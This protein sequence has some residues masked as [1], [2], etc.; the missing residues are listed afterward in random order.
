MY[1]ILLMLVTLAVV[2]QAAEYKAVFDCSSSDS[3]YIKSRMWLVGKTIDMIEKRGDTATV[4]LT[5]HG[6]CVQMV[7]QDYEMITPDED[8][9]NIEKAQNYLISL[10]KRKNVKIIACAMSLSASAI[11][12]SDVIPFVEVS[13]NSFIDTIGYQNDGYALMTFK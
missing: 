12:K 10:S 5:L 2:S 4:A 6:G 3:N 11:E 9:K 1:K 8:I 13:P 7:A